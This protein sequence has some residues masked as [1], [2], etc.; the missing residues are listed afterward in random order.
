MGKMETMPKAATKVPVM[1]EVR[2]VPVATQMWRPVEG[3]RHEMDR[4]LDFGLNPFRAEKARVRHRT[5]LAS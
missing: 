1:V 2:P 4:L 3:L 5:V